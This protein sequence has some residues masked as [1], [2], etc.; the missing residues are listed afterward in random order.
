MRE[1]DNDETK[2]LPIQI[3]EAVYTSCEQ[4]GAMRRAV[5]DRQPFSIFHSAIP[6][7]M[8]EEKLHG[9][10]KR[11]D[12]YDPYSKYYNNVNRKETISRDVAKGLEV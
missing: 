2:M 12:L 5:V 11:R 4:Q 7:Q 6:P 10:E 9:V 1:N 3:N 8:D